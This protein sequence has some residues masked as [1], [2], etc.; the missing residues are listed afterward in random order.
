MNIEDEIRK[1]IN[2]ALG[3]LNIVADFDEDKDLEITLF[4]GTEEISKTYIDLSDV[5]LTIEP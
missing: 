3:E 1:A 4:Q 2:N 5:F